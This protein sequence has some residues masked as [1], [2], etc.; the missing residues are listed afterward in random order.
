[1]QPQC[2]HG[3]ATDAVA[4]TAM[5]VAEQTL[6]PILPNPPSRRPRRL[7]VWAVTLCD[8][9]RNRRGAASGPDTSGSRAAA[10]PGP[11][12]RVTLRHGTN[13]AAKEDAL[14]CPGNSWGGEE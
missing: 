8:P 1:M 13:A 12:E 7:P 4:L 9:P 14:V 3:R 5:L 10:A 11:D 6:G 2:C